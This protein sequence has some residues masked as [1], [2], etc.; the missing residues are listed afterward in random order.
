MGAGQVEYIAVH[1]FALKKAAYCIHC[2]YC[3]Y[4]IY[5][6]GERCKAHIVGAEPQGAHAE[7]RT[8]HWNHSHNHN[9]I[10]KHNHNYIYT[11]IQ[12]YI[13]IQ[14]QPQ[15]QIQIGKDINRENSPICC[16]HSNGMVLFTEGHSNAL[17]VL[18]QPVIR[19][20]W[21]SDSNIS[22]IKTHAC[23]W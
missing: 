10:Y 3:I 8:K 22:H 11:R 9:Y 2:I 18:C 6:V 15:L 5:T 23:R 16:E 1:C 12:P 4:C 19:E 14:I 21:R 20:I 13:Y 17:L 7:C